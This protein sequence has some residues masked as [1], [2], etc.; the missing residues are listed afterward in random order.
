MIV[1]VAAAVLLLLPLLL[2]LLLLL[3]A[4][5]LDL[6][7]VP[8]L[9]VVVVLVV[10]LATVVVVVVVVVAGLLPQSH[11]LY[12]IFHSN[13]FLFRPFQGLNSQAPNKAPT[14]QR[15]HTPH[16]AVDQGQE[17]FVDLPR[18]SPSLSFSCLA[19]SVG[20]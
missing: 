10:V 17:V 18:F 8:V 16:T 13:H 12:Q 20:C 1:L 11:S 6:D 2:R 4:L 7:L 9:V 3:L 5:A 19:R 15:F 14:C